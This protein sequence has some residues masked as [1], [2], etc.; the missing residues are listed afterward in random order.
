M[1][2]LAAA[3]AGA[4]GLQLMTL[5]QLA[6]RLAGGFTRPAV[7]H[8]LEPAIQQAL[9]AGGYAEFEPM[10]ALPGTPRALLTTL[11]KIWDTDL[12]LQALAPKAPRLA[13]LALIERRIYAALPVGALTP[14][15]LRDEA[16][17]RLNSPA[18]PSVPSSWRDVSRLRQ[19]GALFSMPWPIA[20]I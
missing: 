19:S 4:A 15:A 14:R 2:H 17:Q 10:L 7:L 18:P 6:A 9:T 1:Q 16:M 5:P 13:D 8:D 3:R 20:P 12:D 11:R